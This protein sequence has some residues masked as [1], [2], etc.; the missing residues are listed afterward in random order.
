MRNSHRL[1]SLV[2]ALET[3]RDM[4]YSSHAI[5]QSDVFAVPDAAQNNRFADN[6]RIEHCGSPHEPRPCRTMLVLVESL[7]FLGAI[8]ENNKRL[9]TPAAYRSLHRSVVARP[10]RL[11]VVDAQRQ[12][13]FV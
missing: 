5:H 7:K 12:Q 13:P 2:E 1:V 3:P 8:A 11:A 10:S 4:A 9:G 6:P